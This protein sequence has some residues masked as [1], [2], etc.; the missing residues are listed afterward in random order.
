MTTDSELI[1]SVAKRLGWEKDFVAPDLSPEYFMWYSLTTGNNYDRD[2]IPS[3]NACLELLMGSDYDL[4]KINDTYFCSIYDEGGKRITTQL[5][6]KSESHAIL[7]A[8]LGLK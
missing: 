2:E 1:A 3:V 5:S 4:K 6:N 8:I 7:L